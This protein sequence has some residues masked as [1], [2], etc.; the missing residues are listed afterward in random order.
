MK[1]SCALV[2]SHFIR[3]DFRR[4]RFAFGGWVLIN[5]QRVDYDLKNVEQNF[6]ACFKIL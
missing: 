2:F 1:P 5:D 3:K 6:F 4:M